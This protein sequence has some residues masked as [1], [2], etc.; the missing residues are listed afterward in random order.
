MPD[1]RPMSTT[2]SNDLRLILHELE[3][4]PY[5]FDFFQAVRMLHWVGAEGDP[6]SGGTRP[7]GEDGAPAGESVRFRVQPS[8]SFPASEIAAF[9]TAPE[10][11]SGVPQMF[12]TAELTVNFTGAIGPQGVLPRHYTQLVLDRVRHK[13]HALRDFLDLFHHRM[14]SFFYRAWEKYH[15][16]VAFERATFGDR[17]EETDPFTQGLFCL[18]GLGPA[19]LRRRLAVPD[20]AFVFYGGIFAQRP[21]NASTLESLVAEYF[22]VSTRVLQFRGQWLYLTE[23]DQTRLGDVGAGPL[24]QNAQLGVTALVGDRVWSVENRF[25]LRLGPLRYD[26]FERLTPQGAQI[27]EFAD[28]VRMYAGG[29]YD[30]DV[31]LVLHKNE[32]PLVHLSEQAE[33]P[34]RLGWNTWLS[35]SPFRNDVDDAV[36]EVMGVTA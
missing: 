24:G 5:R 35:G 6:A 30:V 17:P 15:F 25:V 2:D 10:S 4:A 20:A 14:I 19:A 8:L 18:V 32:V 29:E 3:N 23:E 9:R 1:L 16:P 22:Q 34:A 26:Q 33:V 31:Q 28:L 12:H 36:F 13:D 11:S 21:P 27:R 7:V